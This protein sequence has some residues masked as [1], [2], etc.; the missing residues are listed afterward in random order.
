MALSQRRISIALRFNRSSLQYKVKR[1]P[2]D[3]VLR[4]R[5]KE[6]A[7]T[8][9]RYGYRCIHLLLQR[10]GWKVNAKRIARLNA[11][12]GVNLRAKSPKHVGDR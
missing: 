6:I 9:I 2:M 5:I 12:E 3:E 10:E 11:L 4:E 1:N 8:R 7:S